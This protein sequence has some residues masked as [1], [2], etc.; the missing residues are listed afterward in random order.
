[1]QQ[2]NI[3]TIGLLVFLLIPI[4]VFGQS[5]KPEDIQKRYWTTEEFTQPKFPEHW[6]NESAIILS[7][8]EYFKYDNF[9]SDKN[10]TMATR[11]QVLLN[12]KAAVKKYTVFEVKDSWFTR[13]DKRI[14]GQG[15]QYFFM[16]IRIV[17][18][19]G[20][21][22]HIDV[23]KEIKE[24]REAEKIA[25]PNLEPGDVIGLLYALY[26]TF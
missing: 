5:E 17:K 23:Q 2:M 24:T 25:V 7:S 19:D 22:V 4:M 18:P 9:R 21:I 20:S 8:Q 13:V 14:F 11:A 10:V 16:G 12:D 26:I 3:K 6:K 15:R 1:M